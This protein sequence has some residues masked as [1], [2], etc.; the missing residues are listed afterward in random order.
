M[1]AFFISLF[2]I[3]AVMAQGSPSAS[4]D[5]ERAMNNAMAN[6]GKIWA[7]AAEREV[8]VIA[9]RACSVALRAVPIETPDK[10]AIKRVPPT[11]DVAPMPQ[12]VVPAP[13]CETAAR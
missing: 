12:V 8:R 4:V 11:K 7:R 10:F 13:P 3:A 1:R 5:K 2:G 9:P 6:L